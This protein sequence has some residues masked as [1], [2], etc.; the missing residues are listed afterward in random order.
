MC[1]QIALVYADAA[2]LVN[3]TLTVTGTD[4]KS[5]AIGQPVNALT[6]ATIM[7]TVVDSDLN[8]DSGNIEVGATYVYLCVINTCIHTHQNTCTSI[9]A[10]ACV[11]DYIIHMWRICPFAR[12]CVAVACREMCPRFRVCLIARNLFHSMSVSFFP[13]CTCL[14]VSVPRFSFDKYLGARASRLLYCVQTST[15]V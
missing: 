8:A 14:F 13:I 1:M 7:V 9:C 5:I 10:H 15:P 2:P 4:Y 6:G 11:H 12:V 3:Q